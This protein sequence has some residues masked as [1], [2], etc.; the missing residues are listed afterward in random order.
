[1]KYI[2][3]KETWGW[4]IKEFNGEVPDNKFFKIFDSREAAE[5]YIDKQQEN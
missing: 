2:I 4:Q 1:M 3:V 5:Q